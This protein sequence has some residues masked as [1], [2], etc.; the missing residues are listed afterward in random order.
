MEREPSPEPAWG[1]PRLEGD[2]LLMAIQSQGCN[3]RGEFQLDASKALTD[4]RRTEDT[5]QRPDSVPRPP[6]PNAVQ[7]LHG[8]SHCAKIGSNEQAEIRFEHIVPRTGATPPEY[9]EV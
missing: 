9:A 1:S 2:P 5:S 7:N 6:D 3:V 8:R 4:R